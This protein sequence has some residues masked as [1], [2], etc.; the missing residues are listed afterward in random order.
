MTIF[1]IEVLT[2]L[3]VLALGALLLLAVAVTLAMWRAS[4]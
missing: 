1:V 3:Y 2:G 4:R